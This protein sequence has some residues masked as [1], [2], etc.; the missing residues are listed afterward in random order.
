MNESRAGGIEFTENFQCFLSA[1]MDALS[2]TDGKVESQFTTRLLEFTQAWEQL[3]SATEPSE[4]ARTSLDPSALEAFIGAFQPALSRL[5]STGILANVWDV[6]GLGRNEVRI[7]GVL[8]WF[9]DCLGDHGLDH[10]LCEVVLDRI[11]KKI[12]VMPDEMMFSNFPKATHLLD[13]AGHARYRANSEVR[14][15]GEQENRVDIVVDGFQVLLF[16][17]VKIDANEGD[18]QIERYQRIAKEKAGSRPWG[19]VYLTLDGVLPEGAQDLQNTVA[20]MWGDISY[21]FRMHAKQLQKGVARHY[22]ETFSD[23]IANL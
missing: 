10:H 17:E 18:K 4:S 16:V 7:A 23:F 14:Q 6:A 15:L 12:S 9:L 2:K 3:P 19:V 11:H 22:I 21:C 8:S 20:L 13:S 5:R 1:W